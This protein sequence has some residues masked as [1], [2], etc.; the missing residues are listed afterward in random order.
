V[1]EPGIPLLVVDAFT[2][3]PFRGN[4]AGVCVLDAPR[5]D[6]W[7]LAVAA[8]LKHAETAFV[9]PAGPGR[10]GLRW[11]TPEAEVPLCGH[12]TLATAHALWET[13]RIDAAEPAVFETLSG[14]LR[15][16]RRADGRITLDFPVAEPV[17]AGA[18][19]ELFEALGLEARPFR[20]TPF[21]ALVELDDA[22]TV[23]ALAPDLA[24]LRDVEFDAAIVTARSDDRRYDVVDRVFG[25]RIG[26]PEDSATGAAACALVPHW[27]SRL[28]PELRIA[29]LSARGAEIHARREG[30]RVLISGNAV[31]VV[32]GALQA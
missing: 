4:P 14:D 27:E 30:N 29:Q 8:E 9:V 25:P 1:G 6:E 22:G 16:T 26:I 21:F 10:F 24:A 19:P 11:W 2:A 31:T 3:E 15:A 28:G 20:C 7:M 12:A 5:P 17:D 32:R 18:R 23:R 13:G